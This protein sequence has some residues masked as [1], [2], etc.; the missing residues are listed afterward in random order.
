MTSRSAIKTL[1]CGLPVARVTMGFAFILIAISD[2]GSPPAASGAESAK[3]YIPDP[4]ADAVAVMDLT[5]H[6]IVKRIT[7]GEKERGPREDPRG[8]ALSPDGRYAYLTT[9]ETASVAVIDTA[10]HE[11]I[12][13]IPLP[14]PEPGNVVTAPDGR[15]LYIPHY[16]QKALTVVRLPEKS[17]R[18]IRLDDFPGDIAVTRD[19]KTLL[20]TS[21]DSDRLLVLDP[22][23]GRIAAVRVGHNPVGIGLTPNGQEAYVSH[24]N[25]RTVAVIDLTQTPIA[26]KSQIEVGM[27]GGAAV[28]VTPDGL[29]ALVVHCCAN[30]AISVIAVATKT[31]ACRLTLAPQGLDPVRIILRPDGSEAIVINSRSRNISI[32][33]PPCGTPRTENVFD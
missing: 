14:L 22:A 4:K 31:V 26:L 20:V 15:T 5:T 23:S 9:H 13:I 16:T 28:A 1:L 32:F 29:H 8:L 7:L 30:S 17:V 33:R 21:R 24:D 11:V 27:A 12:A 19:G 10:T 6:R 3:A 18:V 25:S 2:A